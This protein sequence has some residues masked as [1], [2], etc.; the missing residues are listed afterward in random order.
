MIS[1]KKTL[2]TKPLN[3]VL[4]IRVAVG[5]LF[6][7]QGILKFIDPNQGAVRFTYI[8]FPYP[9][10][11]AH[12]AGS[13]EIVCG[14]LV[15]IGFLTRFAIVPLLIINLTAINTKKFRNYSILHK[16]SVL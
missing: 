7:K 10:F 12:F 14:L 15:T 4:L 8:G 11:T 1:I 3:A 6:F 2:N 5:L 9:D 16:D 13:F